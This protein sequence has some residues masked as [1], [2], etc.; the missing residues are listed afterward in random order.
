MR[1]AN[2]VLRDGRRTLALQGSDGAVFDAGRLGLGHLEGIRDALERG[3]EFMRELAMAS[4][5]RIASAEISS[6]PMFLP[7]AERDAK[8]FC[9]GLNYRS[10]ATELGVPIPERPSI[11]SRYAST[12]VGHE[13]P[14]VIPKSSNAVD[15]EGELAV[16]IGRS[17]KHIGE[18]NALS[19]LAGATCFNDV[20][21]RDFQER[22][23]RIT[24]AKNF[25]GSGPMGPWLVTMD[26]VGD[27]DKLEL[28]TRV[29]GEL[30]QHASTSEFIFTVRFLI[31]LIS[32]VC[33]LRP[34]DAIATGTPAGVGW[35]RTPPNYLKDGDVVE[36]EIEGVGTLR[37]VA[38]RE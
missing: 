35:K 27:I 25:D 30:M 10:H 23:P 29:N 37:N 12:C 26:E 28:R 24:L 4:A 22:L 18:A 21:M 3:D 36:V 32:Q 17:A 19:A 14:I 31:D 34:G 1:L 11:F 7:V 9:V 33:E 6:I 38:R 5:R 20:S 8:I 13:Q 15:W 2:I 16:V